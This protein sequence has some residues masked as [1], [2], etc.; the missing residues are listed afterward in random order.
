MNHRLPLPATPAALPSLHEVQAD[1]TIL[2]RLPI[3]VLAELRRQVRHLDADLGA[4]M[5][6]PTPN[7]QQEASVRGIVDVKKAAELLETSTDSLYR[8]HKRLRL[9]YIDPLDG[10]L[11]FT[12]EEIAEY[13]RRQRRG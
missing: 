1:R 13:V 5:M 3:N 4:A 2:D 8:K 10:R 11:K 9:G 7:S 12:V 6:R